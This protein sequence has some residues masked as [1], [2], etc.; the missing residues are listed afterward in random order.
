MEVSKNWGEFG[1]PEGNGFVP[2]NGST[3]NGFTIFSQENNLL[4]DWELGQF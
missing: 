2:K 4:F 1:G 3:M